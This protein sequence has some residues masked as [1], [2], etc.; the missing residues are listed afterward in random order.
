MPSTIDSLSAREVADIHYIYGFCD[1]NARAASREYHQRFPTRPAVDYRV[2]LAVHRELSENGLH[3]P[4]R[5]RAS[6]VPVDVD[7]QVLRLVYQDPTI[8]TRRIALQLGINHVQVWKILK[9]E[10]LYPFHFRRVQNLHEPDYVGRS[11]F[12]SWLLRQRRLVPKFCD[13]ILWTDEANFNRTGITNFRNLH[14]WMPEEKN[15]LA[16]R[17]A[18]FQIEFSINVW[19]GMISDYLIGPFILPSRLT[20]P[21]YLTFLQEELPDLMSDVDLQTKRKMWFQHDGA[22]AHFSTIVRDYLN[23]LYGDRWIGRGGPVAWP[24]RSPDMT[25][26]DFFLWG[27]MKQIVYSTPIST[28]EELLQKVMAAASQIKENRT[29]LKKTVRSVALRTTVCMDENGGHFE[30]LIN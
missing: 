4:H 15:P 22:P 12:C 5:E 29:V 26:L 24:A 7:E 23:E 8:S 19:A 10:C 27:H 18:S 1:G 20:G 14:L 3:R 16:V 25:P 30:N 2:F 13:R 28:R 11:V 6:T 17:P 9:K 21:A